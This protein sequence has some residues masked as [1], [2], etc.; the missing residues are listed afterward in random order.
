[1]EDF[2]V[3]TVQV[4]SGCQGFPV[5]SWMSA[6]RPLMTPGPGTGAHPGRHRAGVSHPRGTITAQRQQNCPRPPP[7][8]HRESSRLLTAD[9]AT[10]P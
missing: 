5:V 6:S 9:V 4:V 1:M 10:T 2:K 3:V 7:C 8:P